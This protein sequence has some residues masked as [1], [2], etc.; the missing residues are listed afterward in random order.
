MCVRCSSRSRYDSHRPSRLQLFDFVNLRGFQLTFKTGFF[1]TS[2]GV[3]RGVLLTWARYLVLEVKHWF[4]VEEAIPGYHRLWDMLIKRCPNLEELIVDGLSPSEPIDAHRLPR[5]RWP[6]LRV[7]VLGDVVTDW[8]ISLNSAA[9]RS[10][11]TFLDA[12]PSLTTLNLW[13][14][15]PS[16][17]APAILEALQP[18]SLAKVCHFGGTLDQLLAFRHKAHLQSLRV[19]EHILLRESTPL[20]MT[21][22]LSAVPNLTSLQIS[23]TLLRGYDNG[24]IVRS[25][26]SACPLLENLDF[27]CAG[28]PSFK[29]VRLIFG[30]HSH[31]ILKL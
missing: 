3:S 15:Q 17:G 8:H 21:G 30:P 19:V 16:T 6:R 11:V 22:I 25:I 18:E 29:L 7:L 12:H 4:C 26:A 10:F 9:K 28:R 13:G 1:L 5:G 23:F 31:T 27:T 24:N 2:E 20:A 14:R